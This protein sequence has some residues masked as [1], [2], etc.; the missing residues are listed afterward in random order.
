MNYCKHIENGA[1][2]WYKNGKF[3]Q[4]NGPAIEFANGDKEWFQYGRRHRLNGPAMD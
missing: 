2:I 3:H 1:K 4:D